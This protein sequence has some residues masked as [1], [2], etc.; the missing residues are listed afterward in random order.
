MPDTVRVASARALAASPIPPVLPV[1]PAPPRILS[2]P[3]L[4]VLLSLAWPNVLAMLA[5]TAVGVAE[6]LYVGALGRD[7]LAAMAVVFPWVM[8]MQMLSAGSVGGAVA[9][10]V[11]RALGADD[12]GAARQVAWQAALLSLAAGA[13]CTALAWAF[14]PT[15]FRWQGAEGP[16]LDQAL[17]HA[18]V[19]F[20]AAPVIW[21]VNTLISVSRGEGAMRLGA[22]AMLGVTGLQIA[23][24]A[25]L[26]LGLGPL[27]HWGMAG[28]AA[29]QALAFAAVGAAL[30]VLHRGQRLRVPLR[31]RGRRWQPAVASALLRQGS[32]ASLS[33]LQ[34]VA[35][36]VVLTALVSRLGVD[37]LAGYGIGTRLEFLLVPLAFGVGIGCLP[38]VGMA[39]GRGLVARARRVAWTGAALAAGL[40]GTVGVV[41]TAWPAAWAGWFSAQPAVLAQ[42]E[43]YLRHAGPGY[44][45]FGLGMA[46]YFSAQGAGR[47]GG[48]I[49]GSACR[50]ATVLAGGAWLSARDASAAGYFTL[51]ALSM[52]VYG[53]VTALA[54]ARS[55]WGPAPRPATAP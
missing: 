5:T 7:A 46:L 43:S 10:A 13:A 49:L 47:I 26:G 36:V 14:G 45:F 33:P 12:E 34:S 27:P 30:F 2:G 24:G 18:H 23:A 29:G 44:A 16:V 28:V 1:P 4:P 51:V 21:L 41:V 17:A 48:P 15:V 39:L 37:A 52:F 6:T 35:T 22:A 25:G 55:A 50:L 38:M 54:V 19:L 11:S 53:G 31:W 20:S 42:A 32:L 8:L 3:V 9:S 40:L